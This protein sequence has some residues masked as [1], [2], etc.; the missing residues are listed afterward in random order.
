MYR[1]RI[2]VFMS[3]YLAT[4][5][6]QFD[7]FRSWR[8]TNLFFTGWRNLHHFLQFNCC[9]ITVNL[10]H[11]LGNS[12]RCHKLVSNYHYHKIQT[13]K[14]IAVHS[15]QWWDFVKQVSITC[16]RFSTPFYTISVVC[17]VFNSN[18]LK[19]VR[20]TRERHSVKLVLFFSAVILDLMQDANLEAKQR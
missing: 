5:L 13:T 12:F 4:F 10:F 7:V 9:P 15:L 6:W 14:I 2:V 16:I 1:K 18:A 3:S 8:Q 19:G 11:I 20:M 17:V